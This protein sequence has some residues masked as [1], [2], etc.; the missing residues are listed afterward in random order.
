MKD[1]VG[2]ISVLLS[3]TYLLPQIVRICRRQSAADLS[4]PA[5]ALQFV[6]C[7]FFLWY[8]VLIDDDVLVLMAVVNL[9]EIATILLL[10]FVFEAPTEKTEI[11]PIQVVPP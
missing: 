8:N 7:C 10:S 6:S 4:R 2:G 9:V 5:F 11:D 1:V 3:G